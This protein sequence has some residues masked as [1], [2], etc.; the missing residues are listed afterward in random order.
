MM[1]KKEQNGPCPSCPWHCCPRRLAVLL[2]AALFAIHT[3][4]IY[5]A[6]EPKPHGTECRATLRR[7]QTSKFT[8]STPPLPSPHPQMSVISRPASCG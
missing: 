7:N 2:A 1:G 8:Q 5:P 6:R 3:S 4:Q